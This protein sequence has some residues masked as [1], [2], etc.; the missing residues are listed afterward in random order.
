[1]D[2]KKNPFYVEKCR[3]AKSTNEGELVYFDVCKNFRDCIYQHT[4][5][6]KRNLTLLEDSL[7]T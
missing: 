1:M 2:V 4:K 6:D 5:L 3:L 7:V